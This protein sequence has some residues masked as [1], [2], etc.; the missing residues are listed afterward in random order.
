ME[1]G[2]S[3]TLYRTSE[4]IRSSHIYTA[5]GNNNIDFRVGRNI[6]SYSSEARFTNAM[7]INLTA[8]FGVGYEPD[9]NWLD[10]NIDYFEGTISFIRLEGINSRDSVK[11][12]FNLYK[13]YQDYTNVRCYKEGSNTEVA[14]DKTSPIQNDAN[15]RPYKEIT[16]KSVES[17]IRCN[18]NWR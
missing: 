11:I 17:N 10:K 2:N 1:F 14:I 8:S 7:V 12:R 4:W 9:R 3:I 15:G 16:I 13:D 18:A 6:N 5:T